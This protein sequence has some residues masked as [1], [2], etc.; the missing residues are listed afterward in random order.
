MAT[1]ERGERA[2][3]FSVAGL[4]EDPKGAIEEL[5]STD[6]GVVVV[7]GETVV[8][9][10]SATFAR[11]LFE[12]GDAE[13]GEVLGRLL[14]EQPKDFAIDVENGL[15]VETS[16]RTRALTRSDI[17]PPGPDPTPPPTSR[18][19]RCTNGSE[20]HVVRLIGGTV[21]AQCPKQLRAGGPCPGIL[22]AY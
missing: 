14:R 9:A 12:S 7:G 5:Q 1:E 3:L 10:D 8:V 22:E 20:R 19:F 15:L 4:R 17:R 13:L 21:G 18:R 6:F 11:H 2:V 16:G